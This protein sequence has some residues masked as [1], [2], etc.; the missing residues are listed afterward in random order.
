[1]KAL[2]SLIQPAFE[3]TC[4]NSMQVALLVGLVL[5]VQKVLGRWLTPRLRYALSLLILLRLLLL[6]APP[7]PLSLQNLWSRAT[8]PAA[9]PAAAPTV[10]E[11]ISPSAIHP[12][13]LPLDVLAARPVATPA[14]LPPPRRLP[15]LSLAETLGLAW[16][17]GL[18]ALVALAAWRY[19]HWCR[20]IRRGRR[21]SHAGWLALLDQAR[22]V[23]G[24]RRPVTLV[25]IAQL[26]SPAVF[27][28]RQVR[29]LLPETT[30]DQLM[31]QDLRLLFL[32]E[33]AHVRRHDMLLNLLLMAVQFV[34][35]FNPL[36]WL[37]LHRLRADREL[38]CDAMVL[39]HTKPE[40]RLGYGE[41]LL[42]L[43]TDFPAA[44][45][46]V[47]TAVPV[48]SSK[49]EIKRRLVS[50]K[51]YRSASL[52]ACVATG[53]T[54]VTLAC[55]TFTG[56]SQPPPVVPESA[57]S[58]AVT[59]GSVSN[60]LS[61]Y[62]GTVEE[63][64]KASALMRDGA[65]NV[66]SSPALRI[67]EKKITIHLA[68][69]PLDNVLLNLSTNAGV[70]IVADKSLPALTNRLSVKLDEVKLGEV[71]RYLSSTFDLEFHVGGEMVWVVDGKAQ[72]KAPEE[73]R[74]YRLR[75]S[76]QVSPAR[77]EG[78]NNAVMRSA[79]LERTI[80]NQFKGKYMI[81][82]QRGLVV[83]RGSPEQ[84]DVMEKIIRDSG[85]AASPTPQPIA[86]RVQAP[87]L[88][89]LAWRNEWQTNQPGA[90][91]HPDGSPVTDSTELDWLRQVKP[92]DPDP[93]LLQ[94]AFQVKVGSSTVS[95]KPRALYLWFSCPSR[96]PIG[97]D[98]LSLL[99]EADRDI[100]SW[101]PSPAATSW[102]ETDD[103]NGAL[104][105]S[106]AC[107][108]TGDAL[109]VP[110]CVTVRLDYTCGPLERVKELVITPDLATPIPVDDV[111]VVKGYGQDA[112]ERAFIAIA[113]D[114]EKTWSR[115]F[116]VVA[117][118]KDGH[119]GPS[120]R[121]PFGD[122][123]KAAG[124]V[125]K[126]EF[127]LPLAN[128]ARFRIGSRAVRTRQWTDVVMTE[129]KMNLYR[130]GANH[131]LA[132]P[133]MTSR[134]ELGLTL[135]PSR[136]LAVAIPAGKV[137][138]RNAALSQVLEIY[139]MLAGA[140]LV[141]E[142]GVKLPAAS[143]TFSNRADLTCREALHLFENAIR[144]QAGLVVEYQDVKHFTVRPDIRVPT[145][146]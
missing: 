14:A 96:T 19:V 88:R 60:A 67:L 98:Q 97:F 46:I 70:N 55:L 13:P 17:W 143:I 64:L 136:D 139:G 82:C 16:A 39:Q 5:L 52:A 50:I 15:V 91:W 113:V 32:H 26:T 124:G 62:D 2:L 24:V 132:L 78:T 140:N 128:V 112:K 142:Q 65:V 27:G 118:G 54:A 108:L 93:R 49:R 42:K 123:A 137:W 51:H 23:M 76:R 104:G 135:F 111:A 25:A 110:P 146:K 20:L 7:S 45:A 120:I 119:E 87:T 40:E 126:L 31:D 122:T 35:W 33:M 28:F 43:L 75:G 79:D 22:Q 127:D 103:R 37:G 73:T 80:T 102:Q 89:F 94:R 69:M 10:V 105:W 101:G 109:N 36:V 130:K 63:R 145:T 114:E 47:P 107:L 21:V 66:K 133:Q 48:V 116:D 1:M 6:A 90:A 68:N 57:A 53:M 106:M 58:P 71:F 77:P 134:P 12:E 34:H 125:V 83:A 29:L 11:P 129:S 117:V 9:P 59:N 92:A 30:L 84:L 61:G 72:Q 38:V 44:Q 74:F 100:P 144:D 56:S 18:V 138:F 8:S 115:R 3:W 99:D 95:L 141:A 121:R 86:E 131:S 4:N 81:D 41:L 85:F